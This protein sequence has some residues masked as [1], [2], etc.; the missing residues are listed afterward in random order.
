MNKLLKGKVAV[1]TG[2]SSGI[3]RHIAK[4]LINDGENVVIT[5]KNVEKLNQVM[6]RWAT[7]RVEW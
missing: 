4:H 3:G 6:M 2:G 1:V 7:T 5:D